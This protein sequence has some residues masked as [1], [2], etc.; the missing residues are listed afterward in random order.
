MNWRF[1]ED[2]IVCKFYLQHVDSWKTYIDELMIELRHNDF[3]N[4]DKGS[5]R[6][7]I[8]NYEALHAAGRLSNAANQSKNIYNALMLKSENPNLY[9]ALQTYINENY[10]CNDT[11]ESIFTTSPANTHSFIP[12]EP[13]G[14]S[15]Q[16]VLFEMI[17]SR[18]M[19]DSEVYNRAF[20]RRDTFSLIRSGKRGASKKT[21]KQLCFGLKLSYVEAVRLMESAG[22]AFSNNDLSDVIVAYFLK[23]KIFDIFAAN[24]ELYE[25]QAELL[26]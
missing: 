24:I 6:M 19:K 4:R 3:G 23:N 9:N 17:D 20:I 25:H 1:E 5:V 8:Q 15:F 18:N 14:P 12:L 22:Y 13:L 2:Y 11:K 7:R 10:I 21:I 16:E 26:F